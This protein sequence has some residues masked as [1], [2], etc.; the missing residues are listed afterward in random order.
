MFN[1]TVTSSSQWYQWGPGH[2]QCRLCSTC[3][4]YWKKYGGLKNPARI[5]EG[6]QDITS[7][8]KKRTG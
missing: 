7:A 4:Q 6:E 2:M 3:W 1:C 5:A 8:V